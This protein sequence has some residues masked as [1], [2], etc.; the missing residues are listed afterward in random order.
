MKVKISAE[1][2]Q[3]SPGQEVFLK[4]GEG[5]FYLVQNEEFMLVDSRIEIAGQ[6]NSYK[7]TRFE[8][9]DSWVVWA[10]DGKYYQFPTAILT[11]FQKKPQTDSTLT[12]VVVSSLLGLLM[13]GA[14]NFFM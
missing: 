8:V 4:S 3:L 9:N 11:T 5:P 7:E 1:K 12:A 14:L 13:L 10:I 2:K 6:K